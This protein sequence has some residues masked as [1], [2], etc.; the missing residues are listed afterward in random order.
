MSS[1]VKSYFA[2]IETLVFKHLYDNVWAAFKKP[3]KNWERPRII[4]PEGF[5]PE[6]GEKYECI[7]EAS[8]GGVFVY[9]DIDYDPYSA[10]L[11]DEAEPEDVFEFQNQEREGVNKG[12]LGDRLKEAKERTLTA[13]ND[14]QIVKL[15]VE[16]DSRN[17]GKM[18]K[19]Q[20]FQEDPYAEQEQTMRFYYCPEITNLKLGQVVKAKI[21]NVRKTGKVNRKGARI[22]QVRVKP[23]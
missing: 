22:L 19:P 1:V 5:T 3:K 6:N 15:E 13:N 10:S 17:G 16:P 7:V 8:L 23:V 4:I 2:T 14:Q 12:L 9:N 21:I 18:F 20:Y 11:V